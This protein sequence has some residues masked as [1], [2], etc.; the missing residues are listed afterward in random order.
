MLK[1]AYINA[2][3]NI[4]RTSILATWY[5]VVY[6]VYV[7]FSILRLG[8]SPW[9][10]DFH[11]LKYNLLTCVECVWVCE[12]MYLI[13][14]FP[15]ANLEFALFCCNYQLYSTMIGLNSWAST[16]TNLSSLIRN[17]MPGNEDAHLLIQDFFY[18]FCKFLKFPQYGYWNFNEDFCCG[19]SPRIFY[20]IIA[21]L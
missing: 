10:I 3:T 8:Y 18:I 9:T 11:I 12:N 4:L 7:D 19:L 16:Q 20:F 21:G 13:V 6:I 5:E 15:S 14:L 1:R 17:F 2:Y